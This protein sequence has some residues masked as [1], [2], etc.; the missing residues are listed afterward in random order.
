VVLRTVNCKED[1]EDICQDVFL[2]VFRNIGNFKG[3]SKVSTWIASIAWNRSID[4]LRKKGREKLVLTDRLA[5]ATEG[6]TLSTAGEKMDR[7][8]LKKMVHSVIGRLPVQYRTLITLYHLE[9]CQYREIAEITGMPEGTV[10]SYLSRA[11]DLI[12]EEML[13]LVPDIQQVLFE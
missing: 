5:P 9:H 3:E 10:K 13:K 7:Q 12:R 8:H 4:F 6:M 1:A 11:R 2:Q